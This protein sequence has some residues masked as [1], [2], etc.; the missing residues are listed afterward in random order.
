MMLKIV[1]RHALRI[2][3][4]LLALAALVALLGP[5]ALY[6]YGLS[7]IRALPQ[8]PTITL[9]SEQRAA[10]LREFRMH[11]VAE[12]FLKTPW[13]Y[14]FIL[15]DH[16]RLGRNQ[17][18]E[19]HMNHEVLSYVVKT[20]NQHNLKD[21]HTGMWHISGAALGTWLNRNWTAEQI[22]TQ[23]Y[24]DLEQNPVFLTCGTARYGMCPQDQW[25]GTKK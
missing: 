6:W 16:E 8:A 1:L 23:A 17:T 11:D 21:D 10:V 24:L 12:P 20:Y 22:L 19:G 7:N 9:T 2:T 5:W 18:D 4:V 25:K 3:L 15:L 13:H 14:Y